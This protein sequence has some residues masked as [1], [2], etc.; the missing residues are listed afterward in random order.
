M[1]HRWCKVNVKR[2]IGGRKIV[3]VRLNSALFDTKQFFRAYRSPRRCHIWN[4]EPIRIS[5]FDRKFIFLLPKM[6]FFHFYFRAKFHAKN[7]FPG[8]KWN[9][10]ILNQN[11][12]K[13]NFR[14]FWLNARIWS[15]DTF[16]I[17]NIPIYKL[18]ICPKNIIHIECV[19]LNLG[20]TSFDFIFKPNLDYYLL[21][22]FFKKEKFFWNNQKNSSFFNTFGR[23]IF[24][25]G[26]ICWKLSFWGNFWTM[27]RKRLAS[28]LTEIR[29][30]D[31]TAIRKSPEFL[32]I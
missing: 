5:N 7:S 32:S 2:F 17:W 21:S 23:N 19:K 31:F 22:N 10:F 24:N 25:Y 26:E 15:L 18:L 30:I 14:K 16:F 13:L 8:R 4:F 9:L 28:F 27:N 3:L 29:F 11:F 6:G 12:G 20:G 1:T